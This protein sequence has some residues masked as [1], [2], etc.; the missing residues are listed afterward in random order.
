MSSV[1]KYQCN[2]LPKKTCLWN[3]LR[4]V[5]FDV[6]H[7]DFSSIHSFICLFIHPCIHSFIYSFIRSFVHSSVLSFIHSFI[8][9]FTRSFI[10]PLS[11]SDR[12]PWIWR[13]VF[14][15]QEFNWIW[16]PIPVLTRPSVT[17]QPMLPLC[18]SYSLF[19]ATKVSSNTTLDEITQK[20]HSFYNR[21]C[22]HQFDIFYYQIIQHIVS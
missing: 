12:S 20:Y 18:H 19:N 17:D 21:P 3:D 1:F 13:Q 10:R 4:C 14:L 2:W 6:K 5:V 16:S 22:R 9:S 11:I 8:H 15:H 7:F